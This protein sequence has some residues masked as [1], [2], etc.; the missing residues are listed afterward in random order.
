MEPREKQTIPKQR[1]YT[2]IN[3]TLVKGLHFLY[4]E[5]ILFDQVLSITFRRHCARFGLFPLPVP[6]P[7]T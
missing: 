2:K 7:H 4:V 6:K 3:A 5:S 1:V